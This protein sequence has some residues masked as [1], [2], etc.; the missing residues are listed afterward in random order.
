[1]HQMLDNLPVLLERMDSAGRRQLE[2]Q[3]GL[4]DDP[5]LFDA[6]TPEEELAPLAELPSAELLAMEKAVTGLYLSGHP[7]KEYE[8]YLAHLRV[9]PL[10]T[11]LER[12]EENADKADG[13]AVKL[14]GSLSDIRTK[15]TKSGGTMA[16]AVLE[17]LTG[18]VELVLF[19]KTLA[20]LTASLSEG[21][22]AVVNGRLSLREDQPPSVIAD[23][24]TMISS[25]ADLPKPPSRSAKYGLYLRLMSAQDPAWEAV[26]ALLTRSKGDRP[27]FIRFADT[28][29][30]VKAAGLSVR[31]DKALI[32]KLQ[33]L[34]SEANIA[35]ID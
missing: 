21:Q 1:R 30:L 28:G 31:A 15:A 18:T 13:E 9:T 12:A 33:K 23:R 11:L 32:F 17:D 10:N 5:A 16:Y 20:A 29:K 25:P 4:F 22:V 8:P 26:K 7:L 2:G 27:V 19:P 14:F 6:D 24:L 35:V 3:L 34:L